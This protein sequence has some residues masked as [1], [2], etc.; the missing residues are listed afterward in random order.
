MQV[1]DCENDLS[2]R[3]TEARGRLGIFVT[4]IHGSFWQSFTYSF[5]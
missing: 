1:E 2:Q 5:A 4:Y 3:I